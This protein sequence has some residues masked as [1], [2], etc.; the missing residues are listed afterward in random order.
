LLHNR[1]LLYSSLWFARI[2][3]QQAAYQTDFSR[4]ISDGSA[5]GKI[6]SAGGAFEVKGHAKRQPH[7]DSMST[8][9]HRLNSNGC[10]RKFGPTSGRKKKK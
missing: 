4:Q 6:A 10:E 3:Q 2:K 8:E 9:G 1:I 7:L 5:C